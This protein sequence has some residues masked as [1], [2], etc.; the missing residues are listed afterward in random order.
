M[1]LTDE[2][3]L[4][5]IFVGESDRWRGAPLYEAMVLEARR[6]GMAGVTV[7]R[8]VM[9]FGHSSRLHTAKVLRLSE[10]LP[11]VVEIVDRPERIDDFLPALQEMIGDGLVTIESVRV[12]RYGTKEPPA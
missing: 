5:R 10:D 11:M 12:L 1:S 9:G 6:R 2:A 4:L 3:K 8:G 7:L